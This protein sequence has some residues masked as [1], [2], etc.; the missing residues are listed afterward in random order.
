MEA[1]PSLPLRSP[2]AHGFPH[3]E[4]WRVSH[5]TTFRHR[6]PAVRHTR[7][8]HA[9]RTRPA[10][11][12]ISRSNRVSRTRPFKA[13]RLLLLLTHTRVHRTLT[14]RDKVLR[15]DSFSCAGSIYNIFLF[16]SSFCIPLG[17]QER[18]IHR[19]TE[20]MVARRAFE[21]AF[22]RYTA[23]LCPSAV[24][25]ISATG[26]TRTEQGHGRGQ[27]PTDT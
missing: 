7:H 20:W 15:Q 16:S 3:S 21:G 25:R 10:G 13:T 26:I 12:I 17:S 22:S 4:R 1:L 19:A 11:C 5:A 24:A 23:E 8:I 2:Q 27:H 6:P 9:C 14:T 18:W